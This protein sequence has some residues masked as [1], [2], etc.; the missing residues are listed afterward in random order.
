ML[1]G[2]YK[3]PA[4]GTTNLP[5]PGVGCHAGCPLTFDVHSCLKGIKEGEG[6]PPKQVIEHHAEI[7]GRHLCRYTRKHAPVA[8]R[9]RPLQPEALHQPRVRRLHHLPQPVEPARRRLPLL[10]RLS[11]I[12][13]FRQDHGPVVGVPVLDPP[14]AGEAQVPQDRSPVWRASPTRACYALLAARASYPARCAAAS[15]AARRPATSKQSSW[16][17]RIRRVA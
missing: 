7:V 11:R 4:G 14:D 17:S 15:S 9:P 10:G 1:R 3:A 2:Q 5:G 6:G 12:V 8:P 16:F 13:R